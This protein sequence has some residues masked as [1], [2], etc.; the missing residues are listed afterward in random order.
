MAWSLDARLP[1]R[2]GSV[3]EASA[4]EALLIEGNLPAPTSRAAERFTI[5]ANTSHPAGCACCAPRS[6]AAQALARL[7]LARARGD[8]P[9]FRE[10]LVVTGTMGEAAVR[11]ALESD[12][13][14]SAWFRLP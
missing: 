6:S 8:A 14:A 7:F 11:A 5:S 10:V 13:L 12:P 1:V 3:E 2:F 4:D 9:F